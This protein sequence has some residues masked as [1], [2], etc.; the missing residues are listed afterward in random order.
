[1]SN[2]T[3]LRS[4]ILELPPSCIEFWPANPRYA[5]VGTYNLERPETDGETNNTNTEKA[6]QQRNGSLILIDTNGDEVRILQTLPT[7]SAILDL[8]F[9][10]DYQDPIAFAV[11]TSTGSISLYHLTDAAATTDKSTHPQI[12]HVKT[13]QFFPFDVLIT[14]FSWHPKVPI[15][16][17]SLSTGE[18]S[19][20]S[21]KEPMSSTTVC[22]HDLEAWTLSFL[23]NGSGVNSGG[24][25][26][27]LIFS[28][29]QEN[30]DEA[31]SE[32]EPVFKEPRRLSWSD[33]N[34][35][36]AGVTAI[37][38]LMDVSDDLVLT[39]S[40]D[41]HIRLIEAPAVGRRRVLAEANLEG[42]VWRLKRL[43]F[44]D[45]NSITLLVSCMHAGTR[46]VRLSRSNSDDWQ[47]EVLAKFEEH[48]SMNY[49]S[50]CRPAV[51]ENGCRTFVTT[52]FYDRLLCLW[53]F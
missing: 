6:S 39:G 16:G 10:P 51:G 31:F 30:I 5:V 14:A 4:I 52:S 43:D 40:Y 12:A 19:L 18:I 32:V 48:K 3:S 8:H 44:H 41:D 2:I 45:K 13:Y 20:G 15:F 42:G 1:M 34:I 25:D 11:A 46:I 50:D 17:L 36:G 23:P 33:K 49:G 37:L 9:A 53:K 28:E 38:P 21:M 35:H 27:K 47:F 29:L 22:S 26:S 24:D 7:P